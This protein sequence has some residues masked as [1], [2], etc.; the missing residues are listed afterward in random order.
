MGNFLRKTRLDELPQL[1]NVIRGDMSLVGPRPLLS[2]YVPLYS[3]RQA[4]RHEVRPGLTGLAQVEGR[5]SLDWEERFELDVRYVDTWSFPGDVAI[6]LRTVWS[7]VRRD[8]ISAEGHATMPEF[9][10]GADA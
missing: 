1:I 4:R 10:G 5:N 6:I 2:R 3:P 7:V 9:R 8:G